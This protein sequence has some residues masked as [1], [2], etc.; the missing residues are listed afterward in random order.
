MRAIKKYFAFGLIALFL[1]SC[2]NAPNQSWQPKRKY[3]Q[4]KV[5]KKP[6]KN[7]KQ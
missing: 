3:P 5:N 4:S 2:Y 7:K 6:V 1:S